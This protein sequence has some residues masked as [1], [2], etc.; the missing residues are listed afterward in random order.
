[1]SI[2]HFEKKPAVVQ[3]DRCM[4]NQCVTIQLAYHL[5]QT[6]KSCIFEKQECWRVHIA[7]GL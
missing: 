4:H 2:A 6:K 1:M 7:M 3:A 5:A